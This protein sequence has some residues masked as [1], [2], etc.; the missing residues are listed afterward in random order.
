MSFLQLWDSFE[1][2][3]EHWQEN[4]S[5]LESYL[6]FI[7]LRVELEKSASKRLEKITQSPFFR[8]GK[9]TLVPAIEKLSSIYASKLLGSRLCF[10][11][12][13]NEILQPL[14]DL[15][16]TQEQK[17]KEK[18]EQC[19]KLENERKKQ[20]KTLE[21]LKEK[22]WK[23]CKENVQKS[24]NEI[25]QKES[26]SLEAYVRQ[27]DLVNRFNVN[28]VE[29]MGRHLSVFQINEEERLKHLRESLRKLYE[30]ECLTVNGILPELEEMPIVRSK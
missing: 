27:I 24:K 15:I 13:T 20:L 1:A 22:Y 9:N 6:E 3:K 19:K 30:A 25:N 4:K 26:S 8:M 2:V 28:F 18:S 29:E 23:Y 12:I 11:S 5:L 14:K 21:A 10:S 16:H 7:K 17:I